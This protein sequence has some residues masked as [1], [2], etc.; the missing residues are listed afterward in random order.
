MENIFHELNVKSLWLSQQARPDLKLTPGFVYKRIK[1]LDEYDWKKLSQNM[2]YLQY[3]KYLALILYSNGK[4]TAI[5]IG[6][7]YVVHKAIKGHEG[8][9]TSM[10]KEAPMSNFNKIKLNTTSSTE[11]EVVVVGDK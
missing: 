2:M 1:N 6:G 10:G 3:I 5:W 9:F 4:G 11:T 8:L 7:E